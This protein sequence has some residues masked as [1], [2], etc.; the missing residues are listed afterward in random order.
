MPFDGFL[1]SAPYGD[2]AFERLSVGGSGGGPTDVNLT[3]GNVA[4]Q[5]FQ[6][7]IGPALSINLG[8][9]NTALAG[10]PLSIL[11]P[12]YVNLGGGNLALDGAPLSFPTFA[13]ASGLINCAISYAGTDSTIPLYD[14]GDVVRVVATFT[15]SVSGLPAIPAA[16]VFR[17]KTPD[18]VVSTSIVPVNDDTGLYHVDLVAS[19]SGTW[20]LTWIATGVSEEGEFMVSS[21][22]SDLL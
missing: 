9:G 15:D 1:P 5:A 13:G 10:T 20:R 6:L 19:Q 22:Q 21:S 12:I 8:I 16:L 2:A 11:T 4:L 3:V 17:L 7:S 18:G 14:V